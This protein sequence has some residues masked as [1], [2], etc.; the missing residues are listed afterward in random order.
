MA[1]IYL[2]QLDNKQKIKAGL[3]DFSPYMDQQAA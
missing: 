2:Q 1:S 3:G